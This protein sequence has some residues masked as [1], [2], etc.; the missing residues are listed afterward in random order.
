[1][2]FVRFFGFANLTHGVPIERRPD[3]DTNLQK[4]SIFNT[5]NTFI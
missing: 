2:S 4:Q 5:I 3:T 1:M